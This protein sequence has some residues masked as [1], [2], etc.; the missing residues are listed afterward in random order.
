MN[1][2]SPGSKP[3]PMETEPPV[4]SLSN[5]LSHALNATVATGSVF[6]TLE[7]SLWMN[8]LHLALTAV[9]GSRELPAW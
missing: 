5:D 9:N 4:S 2:R 7:S 3:K 6:R 1:D 8:D